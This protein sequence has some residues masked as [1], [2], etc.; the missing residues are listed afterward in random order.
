MSPE[1]LKFIIMA[2]MGLA[3][4]S[5]NTLTENTHNNSTSS[6]L[7][8]SLLKS[9]S[10]DNPEKIRETLRNNFF[11]NAATKLNSDIERKN[12]HSKSFEIKNSFNRV[13]NHLSLFELDRA[14]IVSLTS[15]DSLYF[16]FYNF[17]SYETHLEVYFI[18]DASEETIES[19]ATVYNGDTTILKEFGNLDMVFE[20]IKNAIN[21][22]AETTANSIGHS[23]GT[24][25]ISTEINS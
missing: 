4:C 9:D 8:L 1:I 20:E 7:F 10:Q 11:R 12:L 21:F 22:K 25:D 23:R 18:D 6:A 15:S 14:L 2:Q 16:R 19:V 13:I 3:S 17:P 24:T 5:D